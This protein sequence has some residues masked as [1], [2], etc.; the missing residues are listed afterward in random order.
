MDVLD[1]LVRINKPLLVLAGPGMGKTKAIAYK[2]K[3]LVKELKVEGK[4]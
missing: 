4:L 3:Y 2:I 1:E